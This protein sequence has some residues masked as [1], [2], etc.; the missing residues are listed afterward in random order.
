MMVYLKTENPNNTATCI[1]VTKPLHSH[2][3]INSEESLKSISERQKVAITAHVFQKIIGREDGGRTSGTREDVAEGGL[4]GG[5]RRPESI[6]PSTSGTWSDQ[7]P[8]TQGRKVERRGKGAMHPALERG[9][10]WKPQPRTATERKGLEG[11]TS[12]SG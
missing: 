8:A 5:R 11:W 3:R 4:E 6:H 9:S 7:L 12:D 1:K 2:K 10:G